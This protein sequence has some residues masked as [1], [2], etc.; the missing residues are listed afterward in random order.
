MCAAKKGD[1]SPSEKELFDVISTGNVQEASRLLGCKDVRVNCLDEN[2]MTPLMHA[3][4]K[5]KADMCKLLLRLGADVNC[6]HHEH[7]YTAL[8]FAGLSGKTDITWMMLDAGAET[9]VVNSVGR[10]AAQ[11]AAFVGQHDCVTVINNFFSRARLDYYTKVQG[12]EEEPKLPPKLAGPLHKIIMTT[13][14]NPVKMVMLVKENPLLASPSAL[15]K[16]R[17]VM[18]LICEKCMK[19]R[20]MNEVLAMKMHYISCVLAKCASFLNERD[21]QLDG[22]VK[23]LLKGRESDGFPVYQEKFIRECVRK[24]PYCDATL[25]QQLVRSIAPVAIGN[26]PTALSVLT[27]AITGQVGFMD[28][29]FCTTCGDKGA[30]KRCSIC[31]MVIYCG[32]ACQK[33]HWFTHKKVCKK[34]QE[35]REQHQAQS[36]QVAEESEAIEEASESMKQLNV[37]TNS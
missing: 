33:L 26:D 3:A 19:Q 14:L 28:A 22:L 18:E 29:E 8:M 2:G 23:S 5:G 1:L 9:D 36:S 6:N 24:F 25:L 11:M 7:G 16:C 15:D 17:R 20:D 31:K 34:L 27:Q 13:N 4:Y 35:Q 37:D 32:Q 21:D 10:T 12:L 30:Q